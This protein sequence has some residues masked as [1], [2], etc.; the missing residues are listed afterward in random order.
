MLTGG[1]TVNARFMRQDF[2]DFDPQFTII[3]HGNHK[4]R[5]GS[6]D[7]AIKRRMHLV[8][9][10]VTVP[11]EERDLKLG[12]KLRAEWPGILAWMVEGSREWRE[13]EPPPAKVI[14]AAEDYFESQDT[15]LHW[16]EECCER[17]ANA[18]TPRANLFSSWSYW[19]K[20]RNE[21]IGN[22]ADF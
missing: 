6:I 15:L 3:I 22:Q 10:T 8:P 9:F 14:E 21:V 19:C 1:D 5:L 13:K 17:D 12:E 7:E 11:K 16:L 20:Q 18:K 4:P 2:F